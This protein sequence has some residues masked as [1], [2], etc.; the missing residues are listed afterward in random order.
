MDTFPFILCFIHPG[1]K[2]S[3]AEQCLLLVFVV[4]RAVDPIAAEGFRC[5]YNTNNSFVPIHCTAEILPQFLLF[6]FFL[7]L[8]FI[9]QT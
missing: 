3:M 6:F 2:L 8:L 5:S 9:M 1:F 7:I 4:L